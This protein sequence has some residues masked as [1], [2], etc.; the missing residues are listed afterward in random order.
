MDPGTATGAAERSGSVQ[1]VPGR[2][3]V[4]YNEQ[5]KEDTEVRVATQAGPQTMAAQVAP[6]GAMMTA[7]APSMDTQGLFL[8][9]IALGVLYLILTRSGPA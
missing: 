6:R 8:G 3:G 9:A 2:L 4:Y 1:V 5:A 7:A